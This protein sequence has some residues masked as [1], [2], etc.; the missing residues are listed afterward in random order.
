MEVDGVEWAWDCECNA[1]RRYE[2]FIWNHRFEI[3]R[4]LRVRSEQ[5]HKAAKTQLEGLR[6][7]LV[8][9]GS[10]GLDAVRR[11]V[12]EVEKAEAPKNRSKKPDGTRLDGPVQEVGGSARSR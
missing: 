12:S 8:L 10:P 11:A 7:S 6:V 5:E 4:Y 9:S 1:I 3:A 2:V